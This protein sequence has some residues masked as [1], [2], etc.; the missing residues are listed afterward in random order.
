MEKQ[1]DFRKNP[2]LNAII[3][4][5]VVG[6]GFTYFRYDMAKK[7]K[8]K[9]QINL[10][11]PRLE[12]NDSIAGTISNIYYPDLSIFRFDSTFARLEINN[13]QK[14]QIW[15]SR[16]IENGFPIHRFLQVGD[17]LI[18]MAGSNLVI[19]IKRNKNDTVRYYFK[20]LDENGNLLRPK[21]N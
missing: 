15:T 20:L 6:G 10:E 21:S 9:N 3:I 5:I 11:F 13:L 8:L 7:D 16:E 2:V 4:I 18:K 1:V 17:S 12:L 19:I 14:I